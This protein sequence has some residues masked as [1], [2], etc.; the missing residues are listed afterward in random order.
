MW[1]YQGFEWCSICCLAEPQQGSGNDLPSRVGLICR[2]W[3]LVVVYNSIIGPLELWVPHHGFNQPLIENSVKNV[4]TL[5]RYRLSLSFFPKPHSTTIY[6][7]FTLYSLLQV[8]L[9]WFQAH[10]RMCVGCMQILG[11]FIE[12]P[13]LSI[14]MLWCLKGGLWTSFPRNYNSVAQS[15]LFSII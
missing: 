15:F 14:Y 9:R 10:G 5:N 1:G 6:M 13:C 12:G 3:A 7:T 8:I 2:R 4:S 11:H